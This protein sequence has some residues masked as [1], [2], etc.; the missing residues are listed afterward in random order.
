[1]ET[2]FYDVAGILP[3]SLLQITLLLVLQLLEQPQ[4][5]SS[6]YDE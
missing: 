6:S 3:V 1:M 4:R 5:P 2:G